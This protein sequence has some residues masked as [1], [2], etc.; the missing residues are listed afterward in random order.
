MVRLLDRDPATGITRWF[1]GHDNGGFTIQTEQDCTALIYRNRYVRAERPRSRRYGEFELVA[2]IPL[3]IYWDLKR[4]GV[5]DDSPALKRW[6]NDPDNRAFR[7]RDG[8]L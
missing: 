5:I 8:I 1:H 3:N 2:S 7:V 4:K 6:L